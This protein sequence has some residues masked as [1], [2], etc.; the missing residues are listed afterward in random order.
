MMNATK[1]FR[2]AAVTVQEE[3]AF[4]CSRLKLLAGGCS[5]I[6]SIRGMCSEKATNA[7][8]DVSFRSRLEHLLH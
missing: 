2:G 1:Y 6:C 8:A 4:D 5:N 3:G 7:L